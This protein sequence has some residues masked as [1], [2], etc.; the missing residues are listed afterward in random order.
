MS[1][2]VLCVKGQTDGLPSVSRLLQ[3]SVFASDPRATRITRLGT[4]S[5]HAH[6]STDTHRL[7]VPRIIHRTLQR[8]R[9]REKERENSPRSSIVPLYSAAAVC[10]CYCCCRRFFFSFFRPLCTSISSSYR[11][12]AIFSSLFLD[13]RVPSL[14]YVTNE[15]RRG[16]R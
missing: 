6:S 15:E 13:Y 16:D 12:S 2:S 3:V 7:H 11:G 14:I 8:A 1:A 5:I 9:A 4:S 10:V